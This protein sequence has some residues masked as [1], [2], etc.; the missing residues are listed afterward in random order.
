[1]VYHFTAAA[2]DVASRI[3]SVSLALCLT[4][5]PAAL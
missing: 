4:D 3:A 5:S 1:M 2:P